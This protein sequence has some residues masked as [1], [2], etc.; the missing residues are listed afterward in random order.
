MK[1]A[2][3]ILMNKNFDEISDKYILSRWRKDI[4][5]DDVKSN[6]SND[7]FVTNSDVVERLYKVVNIIKDVERKGLLVK[8]KNQLSKFKRIAENVECVVKENRIM[9]VLVQ[10]NLLLRNDV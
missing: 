8:L 1:Y 4:L 9:V 10:A 3:R 2:F 6:S 7:V 5:L